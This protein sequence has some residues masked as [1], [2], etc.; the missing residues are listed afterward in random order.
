MCNKMAVVL[1]YSLLT[2]C[3]VFY[4]DVS[5][6]YQA[7]ANCELATRK[8]DLKTHTDTNLVITAHC[9]RDECLVQLAVM[10]VVPVGSFVVSG[11]IVL[12][13][14]TAHWLEK[15]GRCDD[16]AVQSSLR[17]FRQ[18]ISNS[19]DNVVNIVSDGD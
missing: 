3:A 4:P 10:A 12:V 14:N 9:K 19:F 6:N 17:K 11:S 13:G 15:Q 1:L 8:L 7:P 18:W 16:S 2:G 5:E